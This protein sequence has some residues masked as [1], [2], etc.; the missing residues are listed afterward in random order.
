MF[1]MIESRLDLDGIRALDLFAGTGALG[2]EA[3]SRGA[4]HI[5]FVESDSRAIAIAK[6]NAASL[7]PEMN[8]G[9]Y[10]GDV[11]TWMKTQL[12]GQYQLILADPPYESGAASLLP[13][14][15]LPLLSSDGIFV[16][17]HD[18]RVKMEGNVGFQTTRNY[19]KSAVSL[20]YPPILE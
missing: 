9:F 8:A 10:Q 4:S 12:E 20:F 15:V 5:D 13:S 14:V 3:V 7:D 17:E 19:G 18:R 6:L 2:F 11:F 16:L 1:N